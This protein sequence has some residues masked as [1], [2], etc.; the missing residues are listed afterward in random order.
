MKLDTKLIHEGED[1]A[2]AKGAVAPPIYQSA[3]FESRPGESY[4]EIRYARLNN[5][6]N[7]LAIQKKISR[8]AGGEACV[9]AASGMAAISTALLAVLR[10]GEHVLVQDCLYGGT[11]SLLTEDLTAAGIT[12]SVIDAKR[13]ETWGEVL[14]PETRAIYVESITNPTLD[15]ACLKE[16]AEFA[17]THG[18]IS[19]IDNTFCSPVNFRP[20]DIGFDIEL[21]SATKYLN[22][23][24]DIVAGC[25]IGGE[26]LVRKVT[27]RLN[28]LGGSLDPHACFLL[29]RGLKTLGLRVT[30]HNENGLSVARFLSSHKDVTR[31]LYPGLEDHPDYHRASGLFTGYGGVVSFEVEGGATRADAF[32]AALELAMFA[33]SLGGVE[34]LIT[35]P[36]LTTHSGL[37]EPDR[38]ASGISDSLVRIALGV[39]SEADLC[40]DLDQALA[41][42]G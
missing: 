5:T 38:E 15:V 23:H 24:S 41:A 11:H 12:H 10:S 35:R 27:H 3:T 17:N 40:L 13:P 22:G 20:L 9:V 25:V 2:R 30:R 14:R 42:S 18:L 34:T 33:P 16:A 7:H 4:D 8:V 31:V 26:E 37:S 28:H 6:P 21:H 32:I 29:H 39:E 36:V 19:L 1:E